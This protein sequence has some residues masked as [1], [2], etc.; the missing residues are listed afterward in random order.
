MCKAECVTVLGKMCK[1][2]SVTILGEMCKE[3]CVTALGEM[4]NE[5]CV[6]VL[7]SHADADVDVQEVCAS[8]SN[9]FRG[10]YFIF[11]FGISGLLSQ[12]VTS[13]TNRIRDNGTS[14]SK[15]NFQS[16]STTF[17]TFQYLCFRQELLEYMDVHNNDASESSEP[18]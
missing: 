11:K 14:Q 3:K 9:K 15:Q 7:M 18:S 1:V 13:I 10:F 16:S 6:T 12:V 4:C 5:K 8:L 17:I 2:K